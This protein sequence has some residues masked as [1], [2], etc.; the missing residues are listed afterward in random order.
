[1]LSQPIESKT[2]CTEM[3]SSVP[4]SYVVSTFF[5]ETPK[6]INLIDLRVSDLSNLKEEDPFLYYSIPAVRKAAMHGISVDQSCLVAPSSSR[7]SSCPVRRSISF[8]STD[9]HHDMEVDEEIAH[10]NI[11]M[12]EYVIEFCQVTR[13]TRISFESPDPLVQDYLHSFDGDNEDDEEDDDCILS[14][15]ESYRKLSIDC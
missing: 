10:V 12:Q 15:L 2:K 8:D 5:K 9:S 4:G 1:M 7:N 13:Q 14:F 11:E 6:Q 3:V